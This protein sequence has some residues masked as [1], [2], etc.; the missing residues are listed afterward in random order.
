M[1]PLAELERI[2]EEPHARARRWREEGGFVV[3][4]IG[5]DVPTELVVAAGAL[6]VRV[7]G[8]PGRPTPLADRW[9]EPHLDP[10]ARSMLERLLGG[11]Y[12]YVDALVVSNDCEAS[13]R[14]FYYLRE[15]VRLG[16]D[17]PCPRPRIF[18]LV[19]LPTATST[20]YNLALADDLRVALGEWCGR[21]IEAEDIR[22]AIA[23]CNESRLLLREAHELRRADTPRLR[24]AD[25]VRLTTAGWFLPPREHAELVQRVL[26]HEH[27]LAEHDGAR[28][29]LTGT[30]H[31]E[32]AAYELI[33]ARGAVVVAE[34]HDAGAPAFLPVD[35]S[36]EPLAAL[37]AHYQSERTPVAKSSASSRAATAAAAAAAARAHA[38]VVYLRAGDE[39]PAWDA[40]DQRDAFEASSIPTLILEDQPYGALTDEAVERIDALLAGKVVA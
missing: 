4:V 28:L 3:G 36:E 40:P 37:V 11:T 27:E 29:F 16:H 20:D 26:Q 9:C 19:H 8:E 39:G 14:V 10:L 17:V 30:A 24:G 12:S 7:T 25:L 22:E 23:L 32:P 13:L 1:T 18:D 33:E 38:A 34:D 21:A 5:A 31:Q 2:V 15:L 35:E 6:A